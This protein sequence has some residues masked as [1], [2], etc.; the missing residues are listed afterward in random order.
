MYMTI[1]IVCFTFRSPN[2]S[3]HCRGAILLYHIN[4]LPLR[5]L[6]D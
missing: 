1:N 2:E 5:C 4:D 6:N 3:V